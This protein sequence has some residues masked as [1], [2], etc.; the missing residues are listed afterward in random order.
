MPTNCSRRCVEALRQRYAGL[1]SRQSPDGSQ[2]WLNW[3]VRLA[4]GHCAGI[5]Q[6]TI[7]PGHS[8]D[9]AFVF[10]PE[11]WGRGVALE[12]CQAVLPHLTEDLGVRTLF[13]T[14]DPANV[15]S[16]RLLERLG[17]SEVPQASYPHGAVEAGDRIFRLNCG[18]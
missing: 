10:A 4:S 16:L 6:A 13:A 18:G 5:V 9:F 17:F 8:A 15:R 14:V 1:E 12:A 3:V 2:Q 7:H 11:Y